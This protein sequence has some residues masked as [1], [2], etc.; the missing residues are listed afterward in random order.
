MIYFDN[1]ATTWPKPQTVIEAMSL[2]MQEAGA[3]P[4]RGGHRM[5]LAAGR[6][7]LEARELVAGL[8]NA[9][10]PVRVV[11]TGNA[12]EALNLALKGVLRSGDHIITSAM[13]HNSVIRPL[14]ALNALGVEVT[15]V[16]GDNIGYINPDDVRKVLKKNTKMIALLHASN[17]VGTIMPVAEIGMVAREY[18]LVYLVDAAQTMGYLDIDVQQMNIDLLAF[19]GH[20]CLYGPQG[21]G[22]LYIR[23]G[24]DLSPLKEGGT[25][26]SSES[27]LQPEVMPDRYESGTPNTVGLAGLAAGVKYINEQGLDKIRAHGQGLLTM[28]VD[29]LRKIS[30]VAVYGPKQPERQVPVVSFNLRSLGS[31]EVAF[32]LD[33]VYDIACRSGLHCAPAAHRSL[34]TLEAGT[35]RLSL[36]YHNT[37]AEVE[38]IL[39][40]IAQVALESE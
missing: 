1:A 19:P 35:V 14:Q 22:G 20:K 8:I 38:K 27:P 30:G 28:L 10:N 4:G 24:L 36:S 40:A 21:T 18:G 39:A 25:G 12:T 33:R 23:D 34:G 26:S 32:L 5:S 13:E 7:I 3:N 9:E 11:F 17:V 37:A 31:S 2:C 29:G 15:A 6:I 16:A